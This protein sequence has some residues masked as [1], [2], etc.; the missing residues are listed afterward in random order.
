[1][2]LRILCVGK[3]KERFYADAAAE[4][5]KRLSRYALVELIEVA[6]EKAPE[7]MSE[8]QR[9][10][11]KR[12]EGERLLSKLAEGEYAIALAIDGKRMDSVAF[13]SCLQGLMNG[14][15]GRIAFIIGGSLGLSD[16]VLVRAD[17]KLSFSEMTF[18]HQVFRVMLLEQVYRAFR[19]I[20]NEP[21]HK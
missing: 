7:N 12:A 3:L 18:S 9:G 6:D 14:G 17:M 20:N 4:F 1:M 11:V 21:Y 19:I 5:L 2:Q 15:H 13:A 8:A 10:Q 16:A